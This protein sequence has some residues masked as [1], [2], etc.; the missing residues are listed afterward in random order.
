M[1]V[2][3]AERESR[4][5]LVVSLWPVASESMWLQQRC[6]RLHIHIFS[7]KITVYS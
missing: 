5:V 3:S 4:D 6:N 2:L 7:Y 1:A